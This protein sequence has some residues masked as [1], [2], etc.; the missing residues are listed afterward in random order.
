M[1]FDRQCAVGRE[2]PGNRGCPG[3]FERLKQLLLP[4][5]PRQPLG[6]LD[7][8]HLIDIH[9]AGYDL[10]IAHRNPKL[11]GQEAHHVVGRLSGPRHSLDADAELMPLY[12]AEGIFL[13]IGG[14]ED[15]EDQNIA[16]PGVKRSFHHPANN[17]R[18][19]NF[20]PLEMK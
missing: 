18:W 4:D 15:I 19:A 17:L 14:A 12:L 7:P 6:R 10:N 3:F 11:L 2:A 5:N 9:P 8:Q 13:G 1:L 20:D 16:V